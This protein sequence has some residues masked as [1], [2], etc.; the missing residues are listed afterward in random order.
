MH[1][2]QPLF[3][4]NKQVNLDGL[5]GPIQF[6]EYGKRKGIELEILNLRNNYFKKVS[7]HK[8]LLSKIT[9]FSWIS[10]CFS[11]GRWHD[12]S[13]FIHIQIGIWS[14]SKRA[15][16][17]ENIL[18]NMGKPLTDESLEGRKLRAV[19]TEACKPH[20]ATRE[21]INNGRDQIIIQCKKDLYIF[22]LFLH[23][24]LWISNFKIP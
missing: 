7:N 11:L 3:F 13:S 8:T 18:P 1:S 6:N 23:F 4:F 15:V 5:S 21:L 14:S 20:I 10:V 19:V 17:F 12:S 2:Q 9:A 16:L 22:H 24:S